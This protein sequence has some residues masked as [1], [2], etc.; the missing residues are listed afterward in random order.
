MRTETYD[1]GTWDL[2]AWECEDAGTWNW[3]A[4]NLTDMGTGNVVRP[5][6]IGLLAYFT[7]RALGTELFQ[8][9]I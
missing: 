7:V 5:D 8:R 6:I 1:S 4:L 3:R 9:W 2:G